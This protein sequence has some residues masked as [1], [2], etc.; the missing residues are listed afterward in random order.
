[1]KL[2]FIGEL[3]IKN[4]D[5]KSTSSSDPKSD[6]NETHAGEAL[7]AVHAVFHSAGAPYDMHAVFQSVGALYAVH[8]VP[9]VQDVHAVHACRRCHPSN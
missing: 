9:A 8:A 3:V 1:M 2:D 6:S 7:Y 5:E 4:K